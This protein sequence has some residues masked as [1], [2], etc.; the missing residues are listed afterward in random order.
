[1]LGTV[2]RSHA[3]IAFDPDRD[4]FKLGVDVPTGC[5][6]FVNV[7]PIHTHEMDR[8]V[9]TVFCKYCAAVT[10]KAD[11][12]FAAELAGSLREL[13]MPDLS[14]SRDM[15]INPDIIRRIDENHMRELFPHQ[16]I[17]GRL[18]GPIPTMEAV[19]AEF[20]NVAQLANR[21]AG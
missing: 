18:G 20:P 7:A 2:E 9:L 3:R 16:D 15:A 21:Y 4:V 6:Q 19:V 11:E 5:D 13:E 1:M 17:E 14:F 10:Q 12:L 8:T